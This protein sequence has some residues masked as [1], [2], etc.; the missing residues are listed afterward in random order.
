MVIAPV[1]FCT[2]VHGIAS[3]REASKVGRVGLK[4][5][6]YFEV[7]STFALAIGLFVAK[8]LQTGSGFNIDPSQR[9]AKAIAAYASR[10]KADSV[11]EHLMAIH[12]RYLRQ[13][14]RRRRP[15]AGAAAR[16]ADRLRHQRPA[17]EGA[18]RHQPGRRP[19]G[20]DLLRGGEDRREGGAG[21]RLRRHRALP[22][23]LDP[24][25]HRPYPR[26]AADRPAGRHADLERRLRRHRGRLRHPGGDP[27]GDPGHPDPGAGR[28]RRH[29]QVHERVPG[30]DQP[31]RQR[32]RLRRGQPL[33]G[34]AGPGA[35]AEGPLARALDARPRRCGADRAASGTG[36]LSPSPHRGHS[37]RSGRCG[38]R[39]RR[40]GR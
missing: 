8:L 3:V 4:A 20:G 40:P 1:V 2:V 11:V 39:P 21:R 22:R 16:R 18:H 6:L 32:R 7:V 37:R 15:A 30:A 29:R 14:L 28:A 9:D 31:D 19:A 10:A 5:I 24:P 12:P 17:G 13:R 26:G 25:L 36:C 35:A 27:L 33:G 38:S 34:R 23:L